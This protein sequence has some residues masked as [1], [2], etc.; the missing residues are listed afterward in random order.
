MLDSRYAMWMLWGP[1]LTFFCNDAYLPTVGIRRDWVLG[2]RSDK[3]WEEIWPDIEPRIAQVL[4][5]GEAT[6]DDR[7]QLF[8]ERSGFS[9]ETYHTFSYSPVYDDVSRIA[10]MLCVVTEVTQ[11]VINERQLHLLRDLA[12]RGSAGQS[13]AQ[14]CQR[15]CEV[16]A[17]YPLDVAFAGLYLFDRAAG[18]AQ[19]MAVSRA[20]PA[21]LLP[22][23][24]ALS[25]SAPWPLAELVRS[26]STQLVTELNDGEVRV[27]AAL[28][29]DPVQRALLLPLKG[30]G[31]Q[32]LGGFLLLGASPRR[33]FDESYRA[34]LELLGAQVAAG[35]AETQAYQAE[36]ER[37]EALAEIDRAKTE[38][39]SNV[40]HEFRTPLTL[41]LGPLE[42]AL[43]A[44]TG[45][46]PRHRDELQ[47]A[48]RNAE[49]LLRLVN[50]LLDFARIETGRIQA[51]YHA[52][53]LAALTAELASVFRSTM[54][55]AGLRLSVSCESLPA[56][57]WVDPDMWEKI[58]LNLL[59]N[60]FKYT[61]KG[62]VQVQLRGTAEQIELTVSDTG[63]GIP[64][65]AQ[66]HLFERFYRV[67][68]ATG[69]THEGTGIGLS[70]VS[71][72]A[73][74]HGGAIRVASEPGRG[75]AFTVRIP[76]GNAHLPPERLRSG[77]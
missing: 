66:A 58:V 47:V 19:R 67:P 42:A 6:W 28:W 39:F 33:P 50:T 16:L 63:I 32:P 18:H 70:L 8:L 60:A 30:S 45:D 43:A 74:Q 4:T 59:A 21:A 68:G 22:S 56:Q 77:A 73:K 29:P 14:A 44:D 3:V 31:S 35:L 26:E 25:S 10:G 48:H 37:A 57:A 27:T 76:A 54:E 46:L 72:L 69:R 38:F 51:Q 62:A 65:E 13:V 24:L 17:Q 41:L 49:R 7:L 40:S 61:L 11:R 9:E 1:E 2:A 23:T 34:F 52:V 15:A 36:R 75:S 71:E 64:R 5:R 12:A 53:D 20:L 55:R